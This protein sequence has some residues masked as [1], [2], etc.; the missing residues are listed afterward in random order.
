MLI[1]GVVGY[2]MNKFEYDPAV[3]FLA[4]VLGPMMEVAFRQSILMYH[5]NFYIFFER[6]SFT[7]L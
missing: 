4:M 7:H 1:F 3:L 2:F 6:P 5:N